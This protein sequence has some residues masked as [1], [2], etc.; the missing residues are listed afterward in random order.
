MSTEYDTKETNPHP[1]R[2]DVQPVPVHITGI[3]AAVSLTHTPARK[4]RIVSRYSTVVLTATNPVAP[5]L[6]D[7]PSRVQACLI[8]HG[9]IFGSGGLNAAY[10]W[11]ADSESAATNA[12]RNQ[13][14]G[15]GAYISATN[16]SPFSPILGS[17]AMW[18]AL[19]NNATKQLVITVIADYCED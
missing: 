4:K 1:P 6:P 10:G 15:A 19:D 5:I 7:D 14:G 16:N 11:L 17:N 13:D 9:D 18:G 3:E 12:A 8:V 2:G